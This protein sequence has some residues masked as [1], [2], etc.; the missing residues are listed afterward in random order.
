[1][2]HLLLLALTLVLASAPSQA[3][4]ELF[5][6]VLSDHVKDG[7]VD[8][9]AIKKD[10]RFAKY[11]KQISS[12]NPS[13]LKGDG[14]KSYWINAYNA[15]TIKLINDNWP[16]KSIMDI[17]KGKAWD[18]VHFVVNGQK[19]TL[20]QIEHKIL[21]PLGDARIHFALVCAAKSC[22]PLRSEA[23]EAGKLSKQL[24][25][26]GR[27]FLRDHDLNKFNV[28]ERTAD[29]SQIFN[30]FGDD[31]A[32]SK[33]GVLKSLTPYLDKEAAADIKKNA[34]KWSVQYLNYDWS[35]NK[36]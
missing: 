4:H 24:N 12:V 32:K 26:Q 14:L 28:R 5:T 34:S 16:V 7:Q 18:E 21:R 17:K 23:Y 30:W 31:F 1:M 2:K 35:L 22:P 13:Q 20:N 19:Y 3:K 33:S 11:L 15:F 25:D 6:Q 9:P 36:Q 29:L 10:S 8:Y 27:T